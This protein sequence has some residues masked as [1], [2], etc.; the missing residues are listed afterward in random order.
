MLINGRLILVNRSYSGSLLQAI[1]R[2]NLSPWV[3]LSGVVAVLAVTRTWQ[4]AMDLFRFG[5][6]HLD[7]L[8]PLCWPAGP[9]WSFC[10]WQ[11][12]SGERLR[13]R[14]GNRIERAIAR[15]TPRRRSRRHRV[16]I[17]NSAS[18][19][20]PGLPSRTVHSGQYRGR[21]PLILSS[22]PPEAGVVPREQHASRA[23]QIQ[24]SQAY[25]RALLAPEQKLCKDAR[26][27]GLGAIR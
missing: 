22:S 18:S 27:F 15:S 17:G 19:L 16:V 3:L 24:C 11:N 4:S 9:F 21:R 25:E 2:P 1:V 8:G 26:D 13:G 10:S 7:V 23:I 5:P 12:R 20:S 6:L 14:R